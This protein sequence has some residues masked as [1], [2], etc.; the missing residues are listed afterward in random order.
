MGNDGG[1]IPGRRD[2]VREKGKEE[3]AEADL[4]AKA[5]SRLCTISKE[6]LRAPVSVCR[7]GNLY[8]Q[9]RLI[10]RLMEKSVPQSH[11][12]IRRLSDVREVV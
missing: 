1:S 3:R 10:E 4:V 9:E 7:L 6:P 8:N 11:S 12:Y 2:L 5:R